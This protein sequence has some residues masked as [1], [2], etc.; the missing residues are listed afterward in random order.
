MSELT[1]LLEL[2][3][4]HRLQ[5]TTKDII[6]GRIK[7]VEQGLPLRASPSVVSG[8]VHTGVSNQAPSTQ[9][10]LARNPDLIPPPPPPAP[11]EVVAQTPATVAAMN[12][13]Q[14]MINQ[15]ISGKPEVGLSSPRKFRGNL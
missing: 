1:F 5:K 8:F 12:A 6:I 11:V 2:L 13:R 14:A 3:L 7:E 9:A 15:A 10:F 4:N